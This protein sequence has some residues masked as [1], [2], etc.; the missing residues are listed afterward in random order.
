MAD[1][2][3]DA[4][5]PAT[6]IDAAAVATAAQAAAAGTAHVEEQRRTDEEARV[7]AERRR[8]Q[9]LPA[10]F[11]PEGISLFPSISHSL[12]FFLSDF[13]HRIGDKNRKVL[14]RLGP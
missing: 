12:S 9:I 5:N 11:G 2:H 7:D 1:A 6:G 10:D 8:A 3:E 14:E 13:I 4:N